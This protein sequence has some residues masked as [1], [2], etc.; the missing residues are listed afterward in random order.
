MVFRP[1]TE[2]IKKF[3]NWIERFDVRHARNWARL[4][5]AEPEAAM[6]EATYWGLLTDCG[7]EVIPNTDL[8][9]DAKGPDFACCKDGHHFFV[10][11]TCIR[12][13]TAIDKT[14]LGHPTSSK[15]QHYSNLNNSIFW[16]CQ[17]KT[18]QCGRANDPCLVAVGTFHF[19]AS[20]LCVTKHHLEDLLTGEPLLA[21]DVDVSRG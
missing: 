3:V 17:N 1:D 18:P 4:Y 21:L 10:E 13:A 15:S 16:E 6:C 7:V 19:P 11:V 20:A 8:T 12:I 2:L 9:G 14:S 5:C